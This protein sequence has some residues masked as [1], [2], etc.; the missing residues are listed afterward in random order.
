MSTSAAID[1]A[2]VVAPTAAAAVVPSDIKLL[3]ITKLDVEFSALVFAQTLLHCCVALWPHRA[4]SSPFP[5][6]FRLTF[7]RARCAR[8][9]TAAHKACEGGSLAG[10]VWW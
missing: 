1:V 6:T 4:S 2:R 7:K 10:D 3:L 8:A 5:S 9:V